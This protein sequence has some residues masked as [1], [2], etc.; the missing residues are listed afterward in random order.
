METSVVLPM[1][2]CTDARAFRHALMRELKTWAVHAV[3]VEENT[4]GLSDSVLAERCFLLPFRYAGKDNVIVDMRGPTL[5][6]SGDVLPPSMVV[7]PDMVICHL[8]EGQ[9]LHA[10]LVLAEGTGRDH[11]KWSHVSHCTWRVV[12]DNHMRFTIRSTGEERADDL[13]KRAMQTTNVFSDA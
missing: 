12:D 10:T 9:R 2:S 6:L 7:Y 3:V 11:V 1:S 8:Q 5:I 13:V 4:S